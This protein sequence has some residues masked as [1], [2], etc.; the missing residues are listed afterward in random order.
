[1]ARTY[2]AAAL[3]FMTAS[4][5]VALAQIAADP[6]RA[7]TGLALVALGLPVYYIWVSPHAHH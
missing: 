1:M 7:S 4:V 3:L 2:R 5:V 6:L